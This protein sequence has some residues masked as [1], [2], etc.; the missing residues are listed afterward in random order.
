MDAN[1]STDADAANTDNAANS[2]DTVGANDADDHDT[3][4]AGGD[5]TAG[6]GDGAATNGDGIAA[7]GG[8]GSSSSDSLN[9]GS[10]T[11]TA[12]SPDTVEVSQ[13]LADLK[14]LKVSG[15][16]ATAAEMLAAGF[17]VDALVYAGYV[18][19]ELL[20]AGITADAYAEGVGMQSLYFDVGVDA[21]SLGEGDGSKANTLA[22]VS[23]IVPV[24]AGAAV[25]LLL[26]L[27]CCCCKGTDNDGD[28]D[29]ED[30]AGKGKG[31]GGT[32]G[33]I[34]GDG[35]LLSTHF[36]HKPFFVN[37]LY[38]GSS[39]SRPSSPMPASGGG[40]GGGD[41]D[42]G[43]FG[44]S[45]PITPVVGSALKPKASQKLQPKPT[46]TPTP[47]LKPKPNPN[48]AA[49]AAAAAAKMADWKASGHKAKVSEAAKQHI[50]QLFEKMEVKAGDGDGSLDFEELESSMA[51]P[52]VHAG[53]VSQLEGLFP[54]TS[55]PEV[56][57]ERL[58]PHLVNGGYSADSTTVLG[59]LNGLSSFAAAR[60]FA[61]ENG[62]DIADADAEIAHH[63]AFLKK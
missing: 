40:G 49:D 53:L 26:V 50:F 31:K 11:E 19:A 24:C 48:A 18:E 43:S 42:G 46:P 51:D 57:A 16:A 36:E 9:A 41:G 52:A 47:T 54:G 37:P 5:S 7:D 22:S 63:K 10:M 8:G 13:I 34:P 62:I 21:S 33:G 60:S 1:S 58:W 15:D 61:I 4:G 30:G 3:D 55:E 12:G 20:A 32:G 25:I 2:N 56:T 6:T 35:M 27:Y 14:A 39:G 28:G 17:G 23:F 45:R 38:D 29:G 44:R 59:F